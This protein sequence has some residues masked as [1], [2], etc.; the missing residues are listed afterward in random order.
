RRLLHD[1]DEDDDVKVL[2]LRGA[3]GCFTAG[4]DL[5]QVY[6]WYEDKGKDA[7][8]APDRHRRP[9]QRKRLAVARRNTGTHHRFVNR[10][11]ITTA[12]AEK[13]ALG[14]R[15]ELVLGADL[16]VLGRGTRVVMP[17][18]RY[19]G[20]ML[21]DLHLFFDR[22]GGVIAKDLL[23]TGRTALAS[24]FASAGIFTR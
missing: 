2:I 7:A 6:G 23:L 9:S 4:Q 18:T 15:L 1:L 3:A 11:K 12:Q 19:L 24:E 8:D 22:L 21:G 16:A 17:A 10:G 20:P 13:Y 5:S 14:G